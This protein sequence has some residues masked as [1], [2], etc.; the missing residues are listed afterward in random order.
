M[1][2]TTGY[3]YLGLPCSLC[4]KLRSQRMRNDAI[5]RAL[6]SA[7]KALGKTSGDRLAASYEK[8]PRQEGMGVASAAAECK[9]RDK[10]QGVSPRCVFQPLA[11]ET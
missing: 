11:V 7:W 3:S 8:E 5:N 1:A 6:K 2:I 9:K 10:Y 4:H